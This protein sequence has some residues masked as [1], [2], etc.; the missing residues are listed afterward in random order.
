MC[1]S[2]DLGL[3]ASLTWSCRPG[4]TILALHQYGDAH[5]RDWAPELV[6]KAGPGK[7]H[8]TLALILDD[9]FGLRFNFGE[10]WTSRFKVFDCFGLRHRVLTR[11]SGFPVRFG[12]CH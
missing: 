11:A 4:F 10:F 5:C 12:G 9:S 6:A 3:A 8:R 7:G 1:Q 2:H